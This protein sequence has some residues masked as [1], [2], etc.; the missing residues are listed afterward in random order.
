M[1][2]SRRY[3]R[4]LQHG[5]EAALFHRNLTA[6]QMPG[7]AVL[8]VEAGLGISLAAEEQAGAADGVNGNDVPGVLGNDVG[9]EEVDFG[10]K[11]G[12]GASVDAAMGVDAVEAFE[13]LGG[14]FD[15]DAVEEWAGTEDACRT[16]V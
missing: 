3:F 10:G 2:Q 12:D 15:L 8:V 13:E 16:R 4:F 5:A 7:F 14:A 9:G 6:E 11:V 1:I